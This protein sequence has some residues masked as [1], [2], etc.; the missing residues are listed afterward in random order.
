[1]PHPVAS[2]PSVASNTHGW[3][4]PSDPRSV[5]I[6]IASCIDLTTLDSLSRTSRYIHDGLIQYRK[7]LLAATLRCTNELEPVDREQALRYRARAS[8]WH[9]MDGGRSYAAKSGSCARD[10]VG[11]CRRC[12]DVICRVI[13]FPPVAS[14]P[15]PLSSISSR[16]RWCYFLPGVCKSVQVDAV[17]TWCPRVC[18]TAPSSRPRQSCCES[19]IVG[20]AWH[21]SAPPYP[22]SRSRPWT[23]TC[24]STRTPFS[25]PCASATRR[26]FGYASPAAAPSGART[27]NTSG[28]CFKPASRGVAD[29]EVGG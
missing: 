2:I 9:Y 27:T 25:A 10:M 7:S 20:S 15:F 18:R 24:R 11:E 14:Q 4:T 19:A 26:A 12:S 22:R 29:G 8:N 21:V 16:C 1:M 13:F 28:K 6:S 23:R 17:L 5:V 3:L